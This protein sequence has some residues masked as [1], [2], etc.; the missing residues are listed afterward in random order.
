MHLI[1]QEGASLSGWHG[2]DHGTAGRYRWD[3]IGRGRPAGKSSAQKVGTEWPWRGNG[4][5][6]NLI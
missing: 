5:W 6:G 4:I 2:L 3:R 1:I